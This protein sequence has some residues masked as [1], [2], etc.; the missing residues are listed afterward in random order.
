MPH[1][2]DRWS[3]CEATARTWALGISDWF[4]DNLTIIDRQ[5]TKRALLVNTQQLEVLYWVGMQ[6]AWGVP[7]RIMI[8]KA[9]RMGMST[10]V[11]ALLTY[12]T[13]TKPNYPAWAIA[14]HSD[15]TDTLGRMA[16]RF[17]DHLPAKYQ[18]PLER[19]NQRQVIYDKPHDSS[20]TF[21]TAGGQAG[22][23]KAGVGR[24]T[25][26]TAAH[27]SEM[28]YIVN[29][30]D[31]AVGL[32]SAVPD[33]YRL[34]AIFKE[35]TANG[36][37]GPFYENWQTASR[38]WAK[39]K[40]KRQVI[41]EIALFFSWLDFPDYRRDVP[42]DYEW[43]EQDEWERD[44]VDMG[45]TDEQLYWRRVFMA[46]KL[47]GDE[48][49]FAQDFPASPDQAFRQSGRPAISARTIARHQAL[50]DAAAGRTKRITLHRDVDRVVY[51]KDADGTEEWWWEV[52]E[53]PREHHWYCV[54]GDVAEGRASDPANERS[55][56]DFH[57]GVC[58]DRRE[59]RFVARGR[60][61][62]IDADEYGWELRKLAEWYNMAW[63]TPEVNNAGLAAMVAFR[64][65]P[66]TYDRVAP[67]DSARDGQSQPLKGWKTTGA[68]RD[69]LIGMWKSRTRHH[70]DTG[71]EGQLQPFSQNLVDE[72][73]TFVRKKDGKQEHAPGCWDDELFAHMI[74]AMIDD[75]LPSGATV[76]VAVDH[77]VP[78]GVIRRDPTAYGGAIAPPDRDAD[79][80]AEW[81]CE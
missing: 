53:G 9:R 68:N 48:E 38:S 52:L 1:Q 34:S 33:G 4:A 81:E 67:I 40:A 45:A 78:H 16:K 46:E 64:D 8:L 76:S 73:K 20:Y 35:S 56:L 3:E 42:D 21:A 41:G 69:P 77:V 66:Y 7:I 27:I 24:S 47:N 54:A 43:G 23:H 59:Q 71:W 5:N 29:W 62:K 61:K 6:L 28:A 22:E 60:G 74:C 44:L 15:G 10:L 31:V 2:P 19:D 37:Q 80:E 39:A 65:Y 14:H 17:R 72:E 49:R 70:P 63:A 13:V 25:E 32:L 30:L 79:S 75:Q 18:L 11:T 12:W 57:A 55:D 36:A 58:L 50:A 51:A 26:A